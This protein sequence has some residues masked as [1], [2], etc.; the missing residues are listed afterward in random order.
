MSKHASTASATHRDHHRRV[1]LGLAIACVL[2][3][4]SLWL[5][6]DDNVR[7]QTRPA[8][9]NQSADAPPTIPAESRDDAKAAAKGDTR[10]A[11]RTLAPIDSAS[12]EPAHEKLCLVVRDSATGAPIADISVHYMLRRINWQQLDDQD[13]LS[14]ESGDWFDRCR[15]L[16][17]TQTSDGSGCVWVRRGSY[18]G[19]AAED[20]TRY[21]KLELDR[22]QIQ[23]DGPFDLLLERAPRPAVKVV[24]MAGKALPHFPLRLRPT[25]AGAPVE[26]APE[27]LATTGRDGIWRI[28]DLQAFLASHWQE[29]DASLPEGLLANQ[30]EEPGEVPIEGIEVRV[31]IPWRPVM[32]QRATT[33][34]L[35]ANP[36]LEPV[37]LQAP[38]TGSVILRAVDPVGRPIGRFGDFWLATKGPIGALAGQVPVADGNGTKFLYAPLGATMIARAY[39]ESGN[40]EA[41][42]TE[43][44]GPQRAGQTVEATLALKVEGVAVAGKLVDPSGAPVAAASFRLHIASGD[45]RRSP[46]GTT[47]G[48]GFFLIELDSDLQDQPLELCYVQL[49]EGAYTTQEEP[50]NE[51]VA[52]GMSYLREGVNDAGTLEVAPLPVLAAGTTIVDGVPAAAEIYAEWLPLAGD[53][54]SWDRIRSTSIETAADGT[55]TLRGIAP[56]ARAYQLY[57]Y[58]PEAIL[59]PTYVPFAVGQA[60]IEAKVEKGGSLTAELLFDPKIDRAA[61]ICRLA[62]IITTPQAAAALDYMWRT[63]WGRSA[64][65]D[66]RDGRMERQWQG[67]VS[68]DYRLTVWTTGCR[69]P[70]VALDN[71]TVAAGSPCTD[72]RLHP[73]DLRGL[74]KPIPIT[75]HFEDDRSNPVYVEATKA[76]A[77]AAEMDDGVVTVVGKPPMNVTVRSNGYEPVWLRDVRDAQTVTLRAL[78][79]VSL[80]IAAVDIPAGWRAWLETSTSTHQTDARVMQ[81]FGPESLSRLLNANKLVELGA[82][83]TMSMRAKEGT[84]IS[85]R[86]FVERIGNE[87]DHREISLAASE[88]VLASTTSEVPIRITSA[89]VRAA[90][91]Q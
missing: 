67:I 53:A 48:D 21:G 62:P 91:G 4:A 33:T 2:A 1:T 81:S 25:R 50:L 18:L 66:E 23:A 7:P 46:H 10:A 15:D 43:F 24:D 69:E 58:L 55:F 17:E 88:R 12:A 72:P 8:A 26:G 68:G 54:D 42:E 5:F 34:I 89:Q 30:S 70:V 60:G 74:V 32:Q 85:M 14:V 57:A 39:I 86:A 49:V 19:A 47:Q 78:P 84:T 31:G 65:R 83:I 87:A 22:E 75:I 20:Q 3:L 11:D 90:T 76:G 56:R 73:I 35:L 71:L 44:P 13:R 6:G 63:P 45:E 64:S 16:G 61:L 51:G 36:P 52:L 40:A 80:A 28:R 9:G 27:R 38:D 59:P 29:P 77:F 37:V 41:P 79:E 82:P